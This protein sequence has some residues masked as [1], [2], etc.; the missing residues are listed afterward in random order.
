MIVKHEM[1]IAV[2]ILNVFNLFITIYSGILFEITNYL[3]FV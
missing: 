2:L 1:N 3:L